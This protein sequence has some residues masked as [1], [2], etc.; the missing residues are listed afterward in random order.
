MR[1][2]IK[3]DYGFIF[4]LCL[5]YL[6]DRQGLFGLTLLSA[7]V[8]E[9]GHILVILLAGN[10]IAQIRLTLLGVCIEL[11]ASNRIS[12]KTEGLIAAGGPVFGILCAI[13]FAK[14]FP[15]FAGLNL[16]LSVFNL[17]PVAPL[18]GGRIM[19]SVLCCFF[20][21]DSVDRCLKWFGTGVGLFLALAV[22][23]LSKSAHCTLGMIL[24]S[25]F[26]IRMCL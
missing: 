2:R 20:Q 10:R 6:F 24:F 3:V 12:Y 4:L 25:A 8:H 22:L 17:L 1:K 13:L 7:G 21:V 14:N 16:C 23:F 26:L 11:E 15:V 9:C 5:L 19:R 18:D